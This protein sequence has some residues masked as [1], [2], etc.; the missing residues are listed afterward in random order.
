[1]SL[2]DRNN[3]YSFNDF[4]EWRKDVD[5]YRDDPF[6]R[7]ALRRYAGDQWRV[8]DRFSLVFGVRADM[9][10]YGKIDAGRVPELIEGHVVGGVPVAK[11][12][13]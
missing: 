5:Y 4:L 6:V 11:W 2:P 7:S 3:P 12:Q 13:V 1:M 10:T 8:N 9:V